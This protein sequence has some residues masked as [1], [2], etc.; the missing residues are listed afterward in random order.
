VRAVGALLIAIA[1]VVGAVA[2]S[3]TLFRALGGEW[4]YCPGGGDCITAY[5][6]TVPALVSAVALALVG[7]RMLRR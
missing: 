5:W 1:L 3:W 4:D 2:A 6:L 7:V